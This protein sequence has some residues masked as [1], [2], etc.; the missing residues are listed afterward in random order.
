MWAG[1][2]GIGKLA[3]A[4]QAAAKKRVAEEMDGLGLGVPETEK[5]F[6]E[7]L[8]SPFMQGKPDSGCLSG[9]ASCP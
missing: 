6:Q 4:D 5:E 9:R 8:S 3:K 7:A 2:F 1:I